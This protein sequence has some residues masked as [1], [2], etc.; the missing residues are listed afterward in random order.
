MEFAR[1]RALAPQV[2]IPLG[3]LAQPAT[4][5]SEEPEVRSTSPKK[6]SDR[7]ASELVHKPMNKDLYVRR[8]LDARQES[9][10]PKAAR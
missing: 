2:E 6:V 8:S 5:I 3:V 4:T 9:N 10:G 7:T 1:P